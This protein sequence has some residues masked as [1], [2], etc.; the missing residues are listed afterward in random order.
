MKLLLIAA[1]AGSA[2]AD[3]FATDAPPDHTVYNCLKVRQD[4]DEA[5]DIIGDGNCDAEVN[6]GPFSYDL[7][8]CW[9]SA[10]AVCEGSSWYTNGRKNFRCSTKTGGIRLG[11]AGSNG[12]TGSAKHD[13]WSGPCDCYETCKGIAERE[14][15]PLVAFDHYSGKCRCWSGTCDASD[16]GSLPCRNGGDTQGVGGPLDGTDNGEVPDDG[17]NWRCPS[18]IYF[19]EHKYD[20]D[21]NDIT[22][23][24]P[25]IEGYLGDGFC[26]DGSTMNQ[27][28]GTSTFGD[29]T[30][31]FNCAAFDYDGGDCTLDCHESIYWATDFVNL[32][33]SFH[34]VDECS[35]G[36]PLAQTA[37]T[38][39]CDCY[40][41]C[42]AAVG[43]GSAF[44]FDH[45]QADQCRC[46]S[47]IDNTTATL[48]V[49]ANT[50]GAT[51]FCGLN[52][53]CQIYEPNVEMDCAGTDYTLGV[54][55]DE[56]VTY[57]DAD[58]VNATVTSWDNY[59]SGNCVASAMC[60]QS[61]WSNGGC[62]A[63]D[64]F[65]TERNND[66]YCSNGVTNL[67]ITNKDLNT[68]IA[69]GYL[70]G[71]TSTDDDNCACLNYCF[72]SFVEANTGGN[73][74][75]AYD[76]FNV[77][78]ALNLA[79]AENDGVCICYDDCS[80]VSAC[81]GATCNTTALNRV[82]YSTV[83]DLNFLE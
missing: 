54:Y 60:M 70:Q 68:L 59:L 75:D 39:A 20:C 82:Y 44:V 34:K 37:F 43:D 57:A 25:N 29:D 69:D 42:A 30:F 50:E 67:N 13:P 11:R 22:F 80:E 33:P 27:V 6:C 58:L 10:D 4:V 56:G 21:G 71:D 51:S 78:A 45:D 83:A 3:P 32:G 79:Y 64:R 5:N 17:N 81:T 16:T 52:S 36:A 14:A 24:Y 12:D 77:I 8:D 61:S 26:D 76:L 15:M 74:E 18:E 55:G 23:R 63:C 41:Y 28:F 7:G 46:F 2:I 65:S 19:P 9:D 35:Q 48:E 31:N 47:E 62:F 72:S 40:A 1:L 66:A 53:N 49:I 38:T 73:S